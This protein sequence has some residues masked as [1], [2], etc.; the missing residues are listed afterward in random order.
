M[1]LIDLLCCM[2]ACLWPQE[3]LLCLRTDV[4]GRGPPWTR[5]YVRVQ[6]GPRPT[7][8][9]G[10]QYLFLHELA[11]LID[12]LCCMHACLWPQECLLS[13]NRW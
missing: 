12:L 6:G 8:T 2:H 5:T 3:C 1:A 9:D 11:T 10:E 13:K 7:R 4:V